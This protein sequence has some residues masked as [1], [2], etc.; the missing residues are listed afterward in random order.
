MVVETS[1]NYYAANE[2][3]GNYL[4]RGEYFKQIP[5]DAVGI[6][7]NDN[8]KPLQYAYVLG[9]YY[10]FQIEGRT[11]ETLTLEPIIQSSHASANYLGCIIS[12]DRQKVYWVN[13]TKPL[14]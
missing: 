11:D 5:D 1:P 10:E 3:T 13:D 9:N 4:L 6:F 12:A 14:P 7:A 2:V 8:D